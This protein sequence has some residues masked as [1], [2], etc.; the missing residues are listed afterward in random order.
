MRLQKIQSCLK[1]VPQQQTSLS[2]AEPKKS[3][4]DFSKLSECEIKSQLASYGINQKSM[5]SKKNQQRLFT[6]LLS[7]VQSGVLPVYMAA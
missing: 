1:V 5:S 7:Y 2:K 4:I 3:S 6:E